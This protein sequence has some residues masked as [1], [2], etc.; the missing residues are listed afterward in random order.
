M[1][2]KFNQNEVKDVKYNGVDVNFLQ[3]NGTEIWRRSAYQPD[4]VV[5]ES[6]VAGN[7]RQEILTTGLYEI[8]CLGGGGGD[9]LY[10]FNYHYGNT[11]R[12]YGALGSGGAGG[13]VKGIFIVPA[14]TMPITVGTPGSSYIYNYFN[15][16]S[17]F[18]SSSVVA[19]RTG[20]NGT[21]SRVG[22]NVIC[23]GGTGGTGGVRSYNTTTFVPSFNVANGTGGSTYVLDYTSLSINRNGGNGN[24]NSAYNLG[25]GTSS[26]SISANGGDSGNNSY[27][28]GPYCEVSTSKTATQ[29][30]Y[31]WNATGNGYVKIVYKG[32]IN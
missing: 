31:R 15:T 19:Y 10:I 9:G 4:E 29:N 2:I 25:T 28:Y 8:T 26:I 17:S 11:T 12:L 23:Y 1:A 3:F 7:Y 6:S 16:G 30:S 24:T 32:P 22:D 18:P 20:S 13:Y 5:F 14:Q 21:E 27:G